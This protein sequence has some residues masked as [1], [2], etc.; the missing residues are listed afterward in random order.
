[1][2]SLDFCVDVAD[3][4]G[5][6]VG[7]NGLA[8]ESAARGVGSMWHHWTEYIFV[9]Y[10]NSSMCDTTKQCVT[11]KVV[12]VS[13]A[14]ADDGAVHSVKTNEKVTSLARGG[15]GEKFISE[16]KSFYS[17]L[18]GYAVDNDLSATCRPTSVEALNVDNSRQTA[19][20]RARFLPLRSTVSR[21]WLNPLTPTIAIWVQHIWS[22]LCQ[23]GL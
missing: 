19:Q 21:T 18:R 13:S 11:S 9:V 22:I 10:I 5:C 7:W 4:G 17:T 23:T 12:T 3:C 20:A 6:S 16:R 15:G 1:V 8:V 2:C 14:W